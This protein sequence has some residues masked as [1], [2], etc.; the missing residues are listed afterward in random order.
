MQK[1]PQTAEA[2]PT[3]PIEPTVKPDKPEKKKRTA[4]RRQAPVDDGGDPGFDGGPVSAR[5][6]AAASGAGTAVLPGC[7]ERPRP[8]R[9]LLRRARRVSA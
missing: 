7:R 1:A 3:P 5:G 6:R 2:E 4:K 9:F 8:R